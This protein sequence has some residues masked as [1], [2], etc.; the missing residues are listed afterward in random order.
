M[1]T[2][3][4]KMTAI[5]DKIREY[6]GETRKINLDEMVSGIQSC[7]DNSRYAGYLEGNEQG[8]DIGKQE[9]HETF[10]NCLTNYGNSLAT[11][12]WD[13]RF[14]SCNFSYIGGFN[15]PSRI[16][17][18]S[19]TQMFRGST[20]IG[21]LTN[22]KVNLTKMRACSYMFYSTSG[23]LEIEEINIS[24]CNSLDYTFGAY[25]L[26]RIGK[27]TLKDTG[28]QTFPNTFINTRALTE[29]G[30]I[31][32]KIGRTVS[33][34]SSPFT[35]DTMKNI[36]NALMDYSTTNTLVYTVTFKADC[37]TALEAESTPKDEGI[38]F[39]GTWREYVI[40]KGWNV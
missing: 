3:N 7:A 31:V 22:D 1:A 40:S 15:P 10:W 17:I 23:P 14:G 39:E 30:E 34:S 37:W 19:G 12:S 13:Y 26:T 4:E 28:T 5:A 27:L 29:I 2:V 21:S 35:P 25:G 32:G 11:E 6:S 20:N 8:K 33:F 16:T 18:K 9:M 36:I 38:D 24:G